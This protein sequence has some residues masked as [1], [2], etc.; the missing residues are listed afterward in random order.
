MADRLYLLI[1]SPEK[2]LCDLLMLKTRVQATDIAQLRI[3]LE[4]DLRIDLGRI[5]ALSKARFHELAQAAAEAV[6]V[7]ERLT[8]RDSPL[9]C[10]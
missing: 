5:K 2:A 9:V 1:A 3:L 7:T 6:A 10:G 8:L 4:K